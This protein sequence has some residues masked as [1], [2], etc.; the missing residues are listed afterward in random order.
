MQTGFTL[1]SLVREKADPSSFP[2]SVI[3]KLFFRDAAW[4]SAATFPPEVALPLLRAEWS[5]NEQL[6]RR[7]STDFSW[8]SPCEPLV[9]M[10]AARNQ[11]DEIPELLEMIAKPFPKDGWV[12]ALAQGLKRAGTTIDKVDKEKKLASVFDQAGASATTA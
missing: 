3:S 2:L 10:I 12:A 8:I 6:L 9:H 1:C 4:P 7:G 11:P 5:R